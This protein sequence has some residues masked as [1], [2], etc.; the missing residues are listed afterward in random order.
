MPGLYADRLAEASLRN[1]KAFW[2]WG[3]PARF[4]H[5]REGE[6]CLPPFWEYGTPPLP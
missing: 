5:R 2:P 1:A 3:H 6:A 4:S